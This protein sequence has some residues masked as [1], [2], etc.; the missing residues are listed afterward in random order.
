VGRCRGTFRPDSHLKSVTRIEGLLI[1]YP[2]AECA[3]RVIARA[4]ATL[5][6]ETSDGERATPQPLAGLKVLDLASLYAA[7]LIATSLADL[8]ADVV[9]V[10]HPRG[11]D[12]RR[13]GLGKNGV[14]L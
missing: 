6:S 10:E 3:R 4:G 11:D 8:G 14:P 5:P 13:W 2:V 12:A 7:P 1:D 9:K